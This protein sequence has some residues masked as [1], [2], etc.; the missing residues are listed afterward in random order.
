MKKKWLKSLIGKTSNET[1]DIFSTLDFNA[2]YGFAKKHKLRER[3]VSS[4]IGI[5]DEFF[6]E[7]LIT[8]IIKEVDLESNAGAIFA[9]AS[10]VKG[11]LTLKGIII[12]L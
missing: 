11:I 3:Q 9:T 12:Y 4:L 6:V 2:F 1:I 5:K 8:Q 10:S 7:V